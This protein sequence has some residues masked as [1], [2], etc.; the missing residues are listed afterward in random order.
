MASFTL[1]FGK[2]TSPTRCI[3]YETPRLPPASQ[4]TYFNTLAANLHLVIYT[5]G[6][7][8]PPAPSCGT[9]LFR[10]KAINYAMHNRA[11]TEASEFFSAVHAQQFDLCFQQPDPVLL[12][13]FHGLWW[14]LRAVHALCRITPG[15]SQHGVAARV[16]SEI[17]CHVVHLGTRDKR[18]ERDVLV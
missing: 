15:I 17:W 10:R 8:L 12:E 3:E 14:V 1:L 13:D 4:D 6:S 16:L 7:Q 18:R 9:R 2:L 11:A 5:G